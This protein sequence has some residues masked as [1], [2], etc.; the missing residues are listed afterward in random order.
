MQRRISV[1]LDSGLS[2]SKMSIGERSSNFK[3]NTSMLEIKLPNLIVTMRHSGKEKSVK[4]RRKSSKTLVT[5][6]RESLATLLATLLLQS[7]KS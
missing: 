1:S 5:D 3:S 6:L 7:R 2:R 4:S